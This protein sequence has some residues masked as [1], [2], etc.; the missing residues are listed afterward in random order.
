MERSI[1]IDMLW[2]FISLL[3]IFIWLFH[4]NIKLLKAYVLERDA[5]LLCVLFKYMNAT[6]IS[7]RVVELG[8]GSNIFYLQFTLSPELLHL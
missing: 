6:G 5:R 2:I 8:Q 3:L 4:V 1:L 7:L